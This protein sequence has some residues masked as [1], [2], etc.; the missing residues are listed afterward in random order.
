M[1]INVVGLLPGGVT[2]ES[3]AEKSSVNLGDGARDC[4]VRLTGILDYVRGRL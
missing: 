1:G 2:G 4:E 3:S